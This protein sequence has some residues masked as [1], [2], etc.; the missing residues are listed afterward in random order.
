MALVPANEDLRRPLERRQG[1]ARRRST[2]PHADPV[3]LSGARD[4]VAIADLR[5]ADIRDGE[6]LRD[7][8]ERLFP[9]ELVELISRK[10]D[11]LL[12]HRLTLRSALIT[13]K[14]SFGGYFRCGAGGKDRSL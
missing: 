9:D 14:A 12:V 13:R 10:P 5:E 8:R 3:A 7:L 6:L 11:G 2:E 4:L 1:R